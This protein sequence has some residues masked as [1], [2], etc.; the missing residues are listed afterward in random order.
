MFPEE[1]DESHTARDRV[2]DRLETGQ[3]SAEARSR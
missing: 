1:T 2:A 3:R